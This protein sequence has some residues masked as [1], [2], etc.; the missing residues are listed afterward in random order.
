MPDIVI[1]SAELNSSHIDE[2]VN[3][4]RSLTRSDA[5]FV[6]DVPTPLYI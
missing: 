3:L 2:I 6:D 5:R 4:E 1:T